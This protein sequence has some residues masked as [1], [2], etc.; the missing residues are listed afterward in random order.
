MRIALLHASPAPGAGEDDQDILAQA[1]AVREALFALGHDVHTVRFS[2]DLGGVAATL[3]GLRPDAAFN[4]VEGAEGKG[5][6]IALAPALLEDIPLPFTGAGSDAMALSSNKIFAKHVLA[7]AGIPTPAARAMDGRILH[8]GDAG[9]G[10]I[11]KSVWEHA[12][13]GLERD[14]VLRD[15]DHGE[16]LRAMARL[17]PRMG[18]QCLAEAYVHGREASVSLLDGPDGPTLLP[19][20]EILFPDQPEHEPR[21]VGWRAKWDDD[22][23]ESKGTPRRFGLEPDLAERLGRAA[24]DCWR[25][26]GLSGYARVDFRVDESGAAQVID[27]NANPCLAPDAGFQAALDRAGVPFASAV[28]RILGAALDAKGY[29]S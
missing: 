23:D 12:S 18:G 6:H 25:A 2:L 22:S 16:L 17:A 11:V 20:A 1:A 26:F 3:N 10:W 7:S 19:P 24:L 4:L 28:E 21:V 9:D 27:V 14:C 15:A 13:I 8:G 5:R 29:A